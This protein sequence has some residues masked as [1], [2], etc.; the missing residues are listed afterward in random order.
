[1]FTGIVQGMAE[2]ISFED[3]T[4]CLLLPELENIEQ[5]ASISI[6][7]VCLTVVSFTQEQVWFDVVSETLQITTLSSL[8]VGDLVNYERA[9]RV[10]DEIGGHDVSGHVSCTATIESWENGLMRFN[11]DA[12]W[13]KYVIAK[14][15]IAID[16]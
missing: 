3:G 14:G 8:S 13:M 16:G 6:D 1:M 5:G 9:A 15:Y 10:G 4:L 12:K 2:V 7:G 11:L